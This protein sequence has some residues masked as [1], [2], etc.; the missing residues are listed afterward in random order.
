VFLLEFDLKSFMEKGRV[1]TVFG[2]DRGRL[3]NEPPFLV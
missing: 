1:N 3:R 2:K